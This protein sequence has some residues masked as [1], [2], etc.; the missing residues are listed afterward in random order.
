MSKESIYK[1][2]T[3][4][5][6]ILIERID[7]ETAT[8]FVN[9]GS[10][11]C[12][13]SDS[14]NN[15]FVP[16]N[17]S[18]QN[19]PLQK[20]EDKSLDESNI[21][22][23]N[24][25]KG[26]ICLKIFFNDINKILEEKVKEWDDSL[27]K[28]NTEFFKNYIDKYQTNVYVSGKIAYD[29]ESVNLADPKLGL[30]ALDLFPDYFRYVKEGMPGYQEIKERWEIELEREI[31]GVNNNAGNDVWRPFLSDYYDLLNPNDLMGTGI[32][33]QSPLE[34]LMD[35]N[36]TPLINNSCPIK[37]VYIDYI[38]F[39]EDTIEAEEK[40]GKYNFIQTEDEEKFKLVPI[41]YIDMTTEKVV[42]QII[43]FDY[44]FN[45]PFYFDQELAVDFILKNE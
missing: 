32:Y 25:K 45:F 11:I 40:L 28:K 37:S 21:I 42:D 10:V 38:P 24:S 7:E 3:P 41:A 34:Y 15:R 44:I 33:P 20:I 27:F 22:N 30:Q 9:L 36:L 18:Q 23:I 39:T 31:R 43:D 16:L 17:V 8:V 26:S 4:F 5:E 29:I 2:I 14:F 35:V 13:A 1:K 19:I 6:C 12:T